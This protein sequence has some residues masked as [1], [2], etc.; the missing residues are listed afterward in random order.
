MEE[1]FYPCNFNFN[2][3]NH[4]DAEMCAVKMYMTISSIYD[5]IICI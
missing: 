1:N 4:M 2:K 3:K 5:A